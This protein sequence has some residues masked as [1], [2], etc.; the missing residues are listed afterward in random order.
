[1]A[2][3][4]DEQCKGRKEKLKWHWQSTK[5]EIMRRAEMVL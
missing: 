2:L 3:L 1:M 4:A 5:R